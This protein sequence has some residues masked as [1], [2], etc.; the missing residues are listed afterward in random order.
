MPKGARSPNRFLG[1]LPTSIF[2]PKTGLAFLANE[3]SP[4]R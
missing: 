3:S 1:W 4:A 2:E